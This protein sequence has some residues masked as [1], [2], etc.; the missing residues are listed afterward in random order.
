MFKQNQRALNI[1]YYFSII[2]NDPDR[3]FTFDIDA[4]LSVTKNN[5]LHFT[6]DL[7]FIYQTDST[8]QLKEAIKS[9]I[10]EEIMIN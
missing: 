8:Q 9:S 6:I 5:N 10:N 7:E 4:S 3:I 1:Q 2:T